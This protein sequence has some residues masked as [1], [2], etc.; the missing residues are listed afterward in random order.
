MLK[1]K[2][3]IE[4][5]M[6]LPMYETGLAAG[7]D[8]KANQYSS[9]NN[10][11]ETLEFSEDGFIL[12][13]NERVLI[14]TGIKVEVPSGYELQVRSRSGMALKN[15]VFVL[16]GLG[17][18]DADYRGDVG[19]ILANFSN[20]NFIIKKGDRIAQFVFNKFEQVEFKIDSLSQTERGTGG[21]GHTGK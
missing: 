3:I 20:E 2:C 6:E 4:D 14:K 13:P 10:L 9:P 17:T 18:V 7:M 8:V 19:V 12:K 21:F 15:G 5:G 11:K 16:N 1:I